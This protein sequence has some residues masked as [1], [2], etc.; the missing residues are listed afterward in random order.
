MRPY[1]ISGRERRAPTVVGNSW[2]FWSSRP[3]RRSPSPRPPAL[4]HAAL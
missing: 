3:C 2:K 1:A 4:R